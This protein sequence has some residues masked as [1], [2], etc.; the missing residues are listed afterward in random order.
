MHRDGAWRYI[1]AAVTTAGGILAVNSKPQTLLILPMLL[2]ALLLV[3]RQGRSWLVRWTLP[4]VAFAA[5]SGVT[6]YLQSHSDPTNTSHMNVYHAVFV[7]ILDGKHDTA[8]DLADLGFPASYARYVG[9]RSWHSNSAWNDPLFPQYRD[10]LTTGNV[11]RYYLTHPVRTTQILNRAATDLLT[12]REDYQGSFAE[13]AGFPPRAKEYRVPVF[14]GLMSL[15]APLGLFFLL[16]IWV[17]TG[18][19]GIRSWRRGRRE[20]GLVVLFVLS[21]SLPQFVLGA[22]GEGIENV[23]HQVIAGFCTAF[24]GVLAV[25]G[26]FPRQPVERE[27]DQ[28]TEPRPVAAM[29]ALTHGV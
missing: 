29:S 26:L 24:A 18:W 25:I 20:I 8:A 6:G 5:V 10:R 3:R 22:L 23:K 21:L 2:V 7:T 19:A 27:D 28:D 4:V 14:S 15:V 13:D 16:P 1:G 11:A 12:T 17:L 9:T